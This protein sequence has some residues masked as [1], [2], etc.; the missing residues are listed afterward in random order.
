M[1]R[2]CLLLCTCVPG[3]SNCYALFRVHDQWSCLVMKATRINGALEVERDFLETLV[4]QKS[5]GA[6]AV[7][8][9]SKPRKDMTRRASAPH[10]TRQH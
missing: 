4:Q 10:E 7:L 3:P 8:L 6:Q 2:K 5:W 1:A 9:S